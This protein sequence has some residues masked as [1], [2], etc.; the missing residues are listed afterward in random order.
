MA[1]IPLALAAGFALPDAQNAI[2]ESVTTRLTTVADLKTVQIRQW[3]NQGREVAQLVSVLQIARNGLRRLL[4][5]GDAEEGNLARR[6]LYAELRA[7]TGIFPSVWSIS[8]LHAKDGQVL[9]STDLALE[10]R[11][12][13]DEGYFRAGQ[14]GLHASPVQY[15]L[16]REAPVLVVSAPLRDGRGGLL[17]VVAVEMNLSDLAAALSSRAGLGETGTAYLVDAYGFYV[18]SPP[19]IE[20]DPL[21]AVA[22]SE[23]VRRALSG[24]DGG[25]TY[26]DPRGISVTGIYRW[27]PEGNL[28]LLVEI[29]KAELTGQIRRAWSLIVLTGLALL[30]LAALVAQYM[31]KRLASPLLRIAAAART[32]RAGDMSR[33]VPIG[34]PDEIGQLAAAFNEMADGLQHSYE[35]LEHLVEQ[36]TAKLSEVN[37]SL[38]DEIAERERTAQ[39]LRERE[40]HYRDIFDEAPGALWID[41]WSRIKQMIDRIAEEGV[42]DWRAY[43]ANNR[44]RLAEAYDLAIV[45]ECS[46]ANLEIYGTSNREAL[47]AASQ[48]AQVLPSELDAFAELLIGIIEGKWSGATESLDDRMDGTEFVARAQY[49]IPLAHRHDWSRI[50]ISLEDVTDRRRAEEEIRKLNEELEQRVE[51]RTAELRAAQDTLLRNERLSTLGQLT[52]TVSHEL[53]NPLGVIRTSAFVLRNALANGEPRVVRSLERIERTVVRCDRIIDELLDFTRISDLEPE[54]VPI[55][56]WLEE[57][58][59]EQVL[60]SGIRIKQSLALPGVSVFLDPDRLRRAVINVFDNACQA[61]LGHGGENDRPDEH[62]LIV[63][64]QEQGGRIEVHFEDNGPGMPPDVCERIF[65]P[66]FS[67]KGFGVGLGLPVVKQIMEQHGGGIEIETEEGRG[68]RVCLWLPSGHTA[69]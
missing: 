54:P 21:R 49:V 37:A 4:D 51:D 8:L 26:L 56:S 15:S 43:F 66:L 22:E 39:A 6:D 40:A 41:D 3:L 32:L 42:E 35:D 16:G 57:V 65:E 31:A 67:T 69:H 12:R 7:I 44:D 48:A 10:G 59:A 19:N 34:G 47:L 60:P 30:L 36:R 45:L 64:T 23:G 17:A 46:N 27:L 20:S 5:S 63:R 52:A 25:A 68:T 58:L 33:R 61:M 53:R 62:L 13:K 9:L 38:T 18:T 14:Q 50:I 24:Q 2:T 55:D 11:E 29:E 28:G 1:F